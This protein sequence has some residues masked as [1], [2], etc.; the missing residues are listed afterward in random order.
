MEARL[1]QE[2]QTA[3]FLQRS[4]KTA[5]E[6]VEVSDRQRNNFV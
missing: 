4:L 6:A 5:E 1:E 2:H 3:A